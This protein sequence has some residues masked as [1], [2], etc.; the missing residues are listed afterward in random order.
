MSFRFAGFYLANA[1]S[2]AQRV[3]RVT[4]ANRMYCLDGETQLR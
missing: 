2:P 3:Y 4:E 1:Y